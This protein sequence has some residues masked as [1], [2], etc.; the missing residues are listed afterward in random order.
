MEEQQKGIHAIK[1]LKKLQK[2]VL[3][4]IT[5][6]DIDFLQGLKQLWSV[7][8]KLGGIKSFDALKTLPSLKFLELWQIRGLADLSFI[9]DLTTL[10]NLFIQSL[11]Q[12]KTLPDFSKNKF[13]R[14]IY[15]EN[16]KGL[17]DF[18]TL[19]HIPNLKEFIIC[20]ENK[21][22][23]NFLPLFEN[24]TVERVAGFL[25]SNKR[26]NQFMDLVNYYQKN[27]YEYSDFEY[28]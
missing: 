9:S 12:V 27:I 4:S 3:R 15:L 26:N 13:L 2:I 17:D 24:P 21:E 11:K 14:R 25:G 5:T 18:S 20:D 1:N 23:N 7:D 19:K 6:T 22:P 8:I 16:M 28:Q 10:Q